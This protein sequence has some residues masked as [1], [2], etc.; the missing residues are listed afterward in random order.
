MNYETEFLKDRVAKLEARLEELITDYRK[1]VRSLAG[2]DELLR[3]HC[4]LLDSEI[5]DAFERIKC[6]EFHAYP[7]FAQDLGR[8]HGIIGDP[9]PGADSPLDRRK[10]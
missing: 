10:P 8:L 7:S 1:A 5:E 6:L 4:G 3:K 2:Y 9:P